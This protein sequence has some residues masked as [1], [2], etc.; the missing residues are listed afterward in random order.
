MV[1]HNADDAPLVEESSYGLNIETETRM[2]IQK[3]EV[4]NIALL[5]SQ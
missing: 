3:K 4:N 1:I 2:V 5:A